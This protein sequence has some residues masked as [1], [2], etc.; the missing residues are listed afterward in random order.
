[1]RG[2]TGLSTVI[3]TA[4][5]LPMIGW[6]PWISGCA[7]PQE[8][9][10]PHNLIIHCIDTL[11][12]GDLGAYGSPDTTSPC[13]DATARSGTIYADAPAPAPWTVPSCASMM[14]GM[15]PGDHRI[16]EPGH[17]LPPGATTLAETM[18]RAGFVTACF[19][20]N[21]L[22]GRM[23]GL[24]RG[25]DT[26]IDGIHPEQIVAWLDA[27]ADDGK[28]FFLYIHAMDPHDPYAPDPRFIAPGTVSADQAD[29][30]REIF[31]EYRDTMRRAS[32][33]L[34][35][36]AALTEPE[37]EEFNRDIIAAAHRV[38]AVREP[39]RQLYLG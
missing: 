14:T 12:A 21:P 38:D 37:T 33:R 5:L 23:I 31:R 9:S 13:I 4:L 27:R 19:T 34:R 16:I 1:M 28:P 24:D 20:D 10:L 26:Y 2:T 39:L 17:F 32:G 8:S 36:M 6:I 22:A 35:E 18:H 25:F 11:R 3:L 7:Q 30:A 29:R 15:L